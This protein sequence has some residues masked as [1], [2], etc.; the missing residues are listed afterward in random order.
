MV[1]DSAEAHGAWRLVDPGRIRALVVDD[2]ADNREVLSGLLDLAGVEVMTAND[3]AEALQRIAERRPDIVFMDVRM[4]V[5]DGL[6][7]V[8]H[9]RERWPED[10]IICIAITA[11][12]LLRQRSYYLHAG[13]DDFIGKPF[14]FETLCDCMARHLQVEFERVPVEDAAGAKK[15]DLGTMH[16]PDPLRS[17]LLAAAEVNALTEIEA[18]IEELKRLDPGAQALAGRLESLLSQYDTDG[19]AALVSQLP[20]GGD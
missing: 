15:E 2:V 11:S 10:R 9:L 17:R 4:P 1:S 18:V 19:I 6:S 20:A 14:R 3:G 16:V 13:F 12:G 5:M 8:Q 7:A